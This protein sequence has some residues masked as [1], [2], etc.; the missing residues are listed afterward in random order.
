MGSDGKINESIPLKASVYAITGD[1]SGNIWLGSKGDGLFQ[2]SKIGNGH[3]IRYKINH[4]TYN[5]NDIY[6]LSSNN[7]YSIFE[8]HL[9]RIWI[10]TYGGG[11]NLLEI[12]G[13]EIR[14]ISARN[15]LRNYPIDECFRSRFIT[16][17]KKGQL[18][19]GTTGGLVVFQ[20]DGKKPEDINFYKY[21]HIPGDKETLSGNDVYSILPASDG[22][23]YLAIF[24]GGINILNDGFD[25]SKRNQIKSFQ[26]ETGIPSNIIF[27]LKLILLIKL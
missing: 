17:D 26:I 25:F 5:A 4:Y 8:D 15:K 3:N 23:L 2:L 22:K 10:A 7:V 19:I 24:G 12:Q 18:L 1:K 9:K 16:E 21:T 13:N 20:A 6:S 14:F 11:L 27:T